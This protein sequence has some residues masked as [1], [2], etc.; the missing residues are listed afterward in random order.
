HTDHP[1]T[2]LQILGAFSITVRHLYQALV[3]GETESITFS[4]LR[5]PEIYLSLTN[6]VLLI[7]IG[8]ATF[9]VGVTAH[10]LKVGMPS[11]LVLQASL[12]LPTTL[13][14]SYRVIPELVLIAISQLLVAFTIAYLFSPKFRRSRYPGVLLGTLIGIGIATKFT[15]FPLTFL[16]FVM[17]PRLSSICVAAVTAGITFLIT[18]SPIISSY[19]RM[20]DWLF[21]LATH[22][23]KYGSG[24]EGFINFSSIQKDFRF[25][26]VSDS[27]F[28]NSTIFLIG[29]YIVISLIIVTLALRK[30][31]RAM[32]EERMFRLSASVRDCYR[33]LSCMILILMVQIVTTVKHPGIRYLIPSMGLI[34]LILFLEGYLL[35]HFI[36]NRNRSNGH[37]LN[38]RSSIP[39]ATLSLV[40]IIGL[41]SFSVH[42]QSLMN[43][44][45]PYRDESLD[46]AEFVQTQHSD[47]VQVGYYGSSSITYALEFGSSFSDRKFASLLS[48]LYPN[49]YFYNIWSK[50]FESFDVSGLNLQDIGKSSCLIL[51]G[52]PFE[53]GDEQ[54]YP[55]FS[56]SPLRT[57]RWQSVYMVDQNNIN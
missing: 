38:L 52:P 41:K 8:L 19:G 2:F 29:L 39:Y 5:S 7:G 50:K 54:F 30:D 35:I 11:A 27:I 48:D 45:Q 47:C 1:G 57:G 13:A 21:S 49:E 53:Q 28:F 16:L 18:T 6:T 37:L 34:S 20:F 10:S 31:K 46:M 33:A 42:S 3:A 9:L 24:D 44:T 22:T 12:F 26:Y 56:F 15:F 36:D 40:V 32:R 43:I 55:E 25:L 51:K 4:V 14:V 17:W 23:G